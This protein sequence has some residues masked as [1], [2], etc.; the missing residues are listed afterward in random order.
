[1]K[2][3]T[4]PTWGRK[5][6]DSRAGPLLADGLLAEAREKSNHNLQTRSC[7]CKGA[8]QGLGR[9]RMDPGSEER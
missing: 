7:V 6:Q 8:A 1:M 3:P 4:P 9:V 5:Q 2:L